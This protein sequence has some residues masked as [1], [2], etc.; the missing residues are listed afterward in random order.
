MRRQFVKTLEKI[1]AEDER[2]V[3]LLGD[4][5]VYGFR[6]A[7]EKYPKRT[8][9]I[10]ICEQSMISLSAGL[11]EE[12]LI[13]VLHSIAP[14]I[15]ERCLE[16][17]KVD[18]AYQQLSVKIVSVGASFDYATLGCTHHCPGDVVELLSI[19][20]VEIIVPGSSKEFDQLFSQAIY[21]PH[22]TYFRLS[23]ESNNIDV[24]VKF[25]H[26]ELLR[27][28]SQGTVIAVGPMLG[29]TI[30]AID[31]LDLTLLYYTTIFPFDTRTLFENVEGKENV[32][33]V[34]PFY[35]GTLAYPISLAL[36]TLPH[37]LLSIGVP[38][39]FRTQYGH[40]EE[41]NEDCGLTSNLIRERIKSFLNESY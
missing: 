5:G 39:E 41:H 9:N 17:I 20:G 31:D 8:I 25:G 12:N 1:M 13:P 34:E 37:K 28:G 23:E 40:L 3:L 21:N 32:V 16:Q 7:F 38:R 26:G 22:T 24:D 10:G 35:E 30:E 14:F 18:L 33:V 15:V 11:A 4:I 27:H 6:H 36:P 19:P 29:R 2:I